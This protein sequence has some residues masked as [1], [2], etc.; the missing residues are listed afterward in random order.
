VDY[1]GLEIATA[2]TDGNPFLRPSSMERAKTRAEKF[3]TSFKEYDPLGAR[4]VRP[5]GLERHAGLRL[6]AMLV[7]ETGF[8]W[9]FG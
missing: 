5:T 6:F 7:P 3:A 8:G 1:V 2:N 4:V 9:T